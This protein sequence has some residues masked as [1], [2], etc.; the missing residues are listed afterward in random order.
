V[1]SANGQAQR[2]QLR[3]IIARPQADVGKD[4]AIA[5]EPAGGAKLADGCVVRIL[6]AVQTTLKLRLND[7]YGNAA[8]F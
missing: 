4:D 2:A 3:S 5:A 7:V 6:R 1:R 8:T